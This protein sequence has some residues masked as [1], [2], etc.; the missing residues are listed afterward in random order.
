MFQL[1]D[2]VV[3]P[4]DGLCVVEDIRTEEFQTGEPRQYYLLRPL[5][6]GGVT[7]YLPV[8]Q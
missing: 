4:R 2:T 8:D 7:V 6:E 3:H 5:A 1:G